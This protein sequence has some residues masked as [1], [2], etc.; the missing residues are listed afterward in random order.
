MKK[1]SGKSFKNFFSKLSKILVFVITIF[2]SCLLAACNVDAATETGYDSEGR[3]RLLQPELIYYEKNP[4]GKTDEFTGSFLVP[5]EYYFDASIDDQL[6]YINGFGTSA[7]KENT[8]NDLDQAGRY[9][10]AAS[11]S[12]IVYPDYTFVVD[13]VIYQV[14]VSVDK[15]KLEFSTGTSSLSSYSDRYVRVSANTNLKDVFKFSYRTGTSGDWLD[16]TATVSGAKEGKGIFIEPVYK[17]AD[18]KFVVSGSYANAGSSDH[19]FYLSFNPIVNA[20]L[21]SR[22]IRVKAVPNLGMNLS[23]S[24]TLTNQSLTYGGRGDSVYS[25]TTSF[26]AIRLSFE[27]NSSNSSVID[28]GSLTYDKSKFYFFEKKNTYSTTTQKEYLSR[29]SGYFPEGRLVEVSREFAKAAD[30]NGIDYAY[31]SWSANKKQTNSAVIKG[32]IY[33]TYYYDQFEDPTSGFNSLFGYDGA[34]YEPVPDGEQYDQAANY[35]NY[36]SANKKFKL[37]VHNLSDGCWQEKRV[38]GMYVRVY[39]NVGGFNLYKL[40]LTTKYFTAINFGSK[41]S[42]EVVNNFSSYPQYRLFELLGAENR[43]SN[44][45]FPSTLYVTANSDFDGYVFYANFVKVNNF[46]VSGTIYD[47]DSILNSK[48]AKLSGV[49]FSVYNK[50][51]EKIPAYDTVSAPYGYKGSVDGS[52]FTISNLPYGSYVDFEKVIDSEN[53]YK[54]YGTYVSDRPLGQNENGIISVLQNNVLKKSQIYAVVV[55]EALGGILYLRPD[56]TSFTYNGLTYYIDSKLNIYDAQNNLST[57][58]V[59]ENLYQTLDLPNVS[60]LGTKFDKDTSLVV[61]VYANDNG[62]IVDP[63]KVGISYEVIKTVSSYVDSLGCIRTTVYASFVLPSNVTI[64]KYNVVTD[65]TI[66]TAI[67]ENSNAENSMILK[68]VTLSEKKQINKYYYLNLEKN[69][70][71]VSKVNSGVNSLRRTE[72][73]VQKVYTY[74]SLSRYSGEDGTETI[75]RIYK[76]V[77]SFDMM[78]EVD[79]DGTTTYDLLK[80]EEIHYSTNA[81]DVNYL[82]EVTSNPD[83]TEIEASQTMSVYNVLVFNGYVYVSGQAGPISLSGL[84]FTSTKSN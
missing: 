54:F 68:T 69:V 5:M 78:A 10:A 45:N 13:G 71:G 4:N 61:N 36:D 3:L 2:A 70:I 65:N 84:E 79:V 77:D 82:Q 6:T 34:K 15:S 32:T 48:D 27:S 66:S 9:A 40:N 20:G 23:L 28:Y 80:L 83:P 31:G 11:M 42:A 56:Q 7:T 8:Y 75:C 52:K 76:S 29:L 53:N 58:F 41:T 63:T 22:K 17:N 64:Q 60:L 18:T 35:F 81:S 50:N 26:N 73:G 46:T 57:N 44:V 16:A 74:H 72:G 19:R 59:A 25:K 62:K 37:Y 12:K 24:N 38:N 43:G 30:G 21:T 33:G 55:K 1:S 49:L 39:K 67:Y 47:S 14:H 51:R